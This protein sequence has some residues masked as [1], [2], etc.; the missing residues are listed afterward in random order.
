MKLCILTY[1]T[2]HMK[3]RQVFAG[4]T[5]RGFKRIDFLTMPFTM[6]PERTVAAPHRPFQFG[7]GP[8]PQ[9]LA[10]R[11]GGRCL[12]Y[13]AWREAW[14][15]VSEDKFPD[16]FILC[17]SNLIDAEFANTG[18]ILNAHAGLIP[19]ARGLDALKWAIYEGQPVGTTLHVIDAETDAGKVLAHYIT[20]IR[21]SDDFATFA[22][23]HYD[24]EID[25]LVC[26]D[27]LLSDGHVIDLR[28]RDA[29][30]RMPIETEREMLDRFEEWKVKFLAEKGLTMSSL[31]LLRGASS[32]S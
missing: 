15:T 12:P 16:W 4:L 3:T 9:E 23:R 22:R 30:M 31:Q 29:R 1:D 6:R 11:S 20:P 28:T 10:R 8:T 17:G 26:F 24:A 27:M 32:R 14:R 25:M 5:H 2:P 19:A 7:D 18:K 21:H 13:E